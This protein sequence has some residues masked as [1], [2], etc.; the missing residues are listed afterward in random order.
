MGLK[1]FN[2]DLAASKAIEINGVSNV[3]RG[4]S[5]G[6]VV[7]TWSLNNAAASLDIQILVLGKHQHPRL[8]VGN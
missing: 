2:Q 5:D 4:D 8:L 3:R 7:F 1:Q 6:E